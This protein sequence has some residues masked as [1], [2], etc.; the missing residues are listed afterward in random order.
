ML[1]L[2]KDQIQDRVNYIKS[3]VN[4]SNAASGSEVD[5]N[6]NVSSKNIATLSADSD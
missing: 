1:N 4:A 6:A 2:R 5:A 3:Y